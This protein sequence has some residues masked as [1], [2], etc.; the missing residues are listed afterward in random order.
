M[1]LPLETLL[2]A[3]STS[4]ARLRSLPPPSD[5]AAHLRALAR[6]LSLGDPAPARLAAW[7]LLRDA[8]SAHRD[9]PE[10]ARAIEA[11]LGCDGWTVRLQTCHLLA[12]IDCPPSLHDDAVAFLENA[13]TDRRVIVRAWALTALERSSRVDTS[14][15]PRYRKLRDLAARDAAPSMRARLRRLPKN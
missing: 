3:P 7:L 12:R 9:A 4:L 13:F 11:A 15:R 6:I 1:S 2:R 10:L 8:P 5:L 14:L